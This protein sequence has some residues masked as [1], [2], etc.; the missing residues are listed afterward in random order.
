MSICS[1]GL[2]DISA[3]SGSPPNDRD[4]H[5]R[6]L[7]IDS[8]LDGQADIRGRVVVSL[9]EFQGILLGMRGSINI[10]RN[11]PPKL[12][13]VSPSSTACGNAANFMDAIA[14]LFLKKVF[15]ALS[16]SF[17]RVY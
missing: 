5:F 17:N 4:C 13:A 14:R 1:A 2:L 6:S 16:S 11:P 9:Q 12:T 7:R 8:G 15:T 3:I 10:N